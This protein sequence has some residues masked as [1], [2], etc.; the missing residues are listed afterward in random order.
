MIEHFEEH[1]ASEFELGR[2]LG[3][4]RRRHMLLLIVLASVWAAVWGSSWFLQ[5]RYKSSTLILVEEPT[6]PK[7]YV[8]PNVSE[9]LQSRLQSISQQILSRTRLLMIIDSLQLYNGNKGKLSPDDKVERMRKDI[10]E[11]EL[12]HNQAGEI[13]AFRVSYSA[14][15]PH[16]AQRVTSELTKLFIN[17]NLNVREHQSENTTQFL[18]NQLAIA[19]SNLADQEAKVRTFQASHEGSLPTQEASNLQILSGLQSQ[20]QNEQ[21]ALNAVRQQRAYHQ[22]M[23]DQYRALRAT[24][25]GTVT[26][27]GLTEI[28][29]QLEKLRAKLADLSTRYTDQF[30][31]VAQVKAEIARTE[32]NRDELIADLKKSANA[33]DRASDGQTTDVAEAGQNSTLLQFQSQLKSDELEIANRQEGIAALKARIN[34]YQARLS[35]EPAVAQQL[36]DL[37]RGYDQSQ[38]NYNDLLKKE[39][40]SRMAT[41]MEQMQEGER[42]SIIDPPSLPL[43]PD[44]PNRLKMCLA[45][46]GAG[47]A[48]GFLLVGVL[49][50]L[51]DRLYTDAEIHRMLS[52]PVISEVPEIVGVTEQRRERNKLLLGWATAVAVVMVILAAA[53]FSYLHA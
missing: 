12:V 7:N 49:E 17:E 39:S 53:A 28:D 5:A 15:D 14:P 32:K 31:E 37:T 44:F 3:F 43:K 23:I 11:V 2:Y 47:L 27:S 29:Q 4:I 41:S 46:A 10:G 48:L 26:T 52:T 13:T 40:D 34:E 45:G 24:P 21:D 38:T 35:E 51:D 33:K 36:A 42:F 16:L 8:E 22:S 20:L 19:R 9:D 18:Q 50:F 30:P 25:G 6:M 1:S